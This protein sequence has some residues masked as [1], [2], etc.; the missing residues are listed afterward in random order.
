MIEKYDLLHQPPSPYETASGIEATAPS[1]Q[2]PA[3]SYGSHAHI[4]PW[5]TNR[6]EEN[7]SSSAP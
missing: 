6:F 5:A 4:P 2:V 1:N 7:L 3:S